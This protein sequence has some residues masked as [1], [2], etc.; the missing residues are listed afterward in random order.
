MEK[1]LEE[2]ARVFEGNMSN[3]DTRMEILLKRLATKH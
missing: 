3:L 1:S 2:N